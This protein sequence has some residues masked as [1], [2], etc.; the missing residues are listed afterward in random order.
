MIVHPFARASLIC[1]CVICAKV[2][3]EKYKVR[4]MLSEVRSGRHES[5]S[6]ISSSLIHESRSLN[7]LLEQ[8][9]HVFIFFSYESLMFRRMAADLKSK[10]HLQLYVL[11]VRAVDFVKTSPNCFS[12]KI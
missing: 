11:F 3:A 8:S 7:T 5:I 12:V 9:F 10:F 2:L 4:E 6:A 1:V